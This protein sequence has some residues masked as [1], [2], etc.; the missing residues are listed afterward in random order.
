MQLGP[1]GKILSR[2]QKVSQIDRESDI[3]A[4][5]ESSDDA[6]DFFVQGNDLSPTLR[7]SSFAASEMSAVSAQVA[8]A[9][10][11]IRQSPIR[12]DPRFAQTPRQSLNQAASLADDVSSPDSTAGRSTRSI[13]SFFASQT[14]SPAFRS[15]A[16]KLSMMK[17]YVSANLGADAVPRSLASELDAA[18][19]PS[20]VSDHDGGWAPTQIAGLT[21][22]KA[23]GRTSPLRE[24]EPTASPT[25]RTVHG[26]RHSESDELDSELGSGSPF[27]SP[28][29]LPHQVSEAL[30]V[31]A[32]T[33]HPGDTGHR[34]VKYQRPG[35]VSPLSHITVAGSHTSYTE[36][37]QTRPSGGLSRLGY[38]AK[39]QPLRASGPG[40]KQISG[41]YGSLPALDRPSGYALGL[42]KDLTAAGPDSLRDAAMCVQSSRPQFPRLSSGSSRSSDIAL[43]HRRRLPS[44]VATTVG[45]GRQSSTAVETAGPP[46][47]ASSELPN[48]QLSRPT[49]VLILEDIVTWLAILLEWMEFVLI[50]VIKIFLEARRGRSK[51]AWVLIARH[52]FLQLIVLCRSALRQVAGRKRNFV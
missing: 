28:A 51:A 7:R 39:R 2:D 9:L 35:V 40:S 29:P 48:R 49:V 20:N 34:Q 21:S 10:P 50:L 17:D 5:D 11:A 41:R 6:S 30:S 31:M 23:S 3:A 26:L 43:A 37:A 16:K 25:Q 1:G 52:R 27:C 15:L 13:T 24:V 46:S 14:P 8:C 38:A 32:R 19:R 44:E 12:V 33:F 42:R 22:S 4:S 45:A 18:E 47:T 36:W